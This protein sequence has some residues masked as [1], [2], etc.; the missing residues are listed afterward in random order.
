MEG[1]TAAK[2]R[3]LTAATTGEVGSFEV[4]LVGGRGALEVVE[5]VGEGGGSRVRSHTPRPQTRQPKMKLRRREK[6]TP[7]KSR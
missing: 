6:G 4:S 1:W 5:E 7:S 3:G 2:G